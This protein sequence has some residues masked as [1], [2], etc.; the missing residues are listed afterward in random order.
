MI[1]AVSQLQHVPAKWNP[2]RNGE[3]LFADKDMRNF[4]HPMAMQ[5]CTPDISYCHAVRC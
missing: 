5:C 1:G 2:V 3:P 4:A